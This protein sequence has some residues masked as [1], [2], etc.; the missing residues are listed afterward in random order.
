MKHN[1][2]SI[3]LD[4]SLVHELG[5]EGWQDE[6]RM[7]GPSYTYIKGRVPG[8]PRF[9]DGRVESYKVIRN[10]RTDE[11]V[12]YDTENGPD[13]RLLFRSFEAA[14]DFVMREAA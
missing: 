9:T 7:E 14:Y 5:S 1:L 11:Y 12:V 6:S 2:F 8:Q 3:S 13:V 4:G 10:G